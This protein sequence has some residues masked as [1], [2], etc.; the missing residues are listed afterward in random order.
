MRISFLGDIMTGDHQVSFSKDLEAHLA[1]SDI[2]IGNL[3]GPIT[4]ARPRQ[5]KR[6]PLHM[7]PEVGFF[8]KPY[9]LNALILANNHIMDHGIDGL[10]NTQLYLDHLSIS[11]VGA[12]INI[13]EAAKPLILKAEGASICVVA[14][15]H[16]EG[17]MATKDTPGPCPLFAYE[18]L[19][20]Y[21][22]E[23][24]KEN[25]FLVLSYHGGE[26]FF[27]VPW[28]RRQKLFEIFVQA[29]VD[30]VFG[31]H[32]H[33]VQGYKK[34]G[35]S[36]IIYGAGNFYMNTPHQLSN[37]GTELGAIFDVE[38]TALKSELNIY[39]IPTYA[40]HLSKRVVMAS[41]HQ[42]EKVEHI[43]TMSRKCLT[44]P[45]LHSKEWN[46]QSFK[47]FK[48]R[49][50]WVGIVYRLC[51]FCWTKRELFKRDADLT[52]KRDR[53]IAVGAIQHIFSKIY[54]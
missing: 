16:N 6:R 45:E 25:D 28:V 37:P 40:N 1:Q 50:R 12:G 8:S 23:L 30:I 13:H 31:H 39:Y 20:N 10:V 11:Y 44:D 51:R 53:D 52:E 34:L 18:I 29:G 24:K 14:F 22:N 26:E 15:S 46:R 41:G 9:H 17:P 3:E 47:R 36:A 35:C 54:R 33:A 49:Y 42:K 19:F 2:V 48:G 32:A 43:I 21:L 38:Y 5:D 7:D 4:A 27:T